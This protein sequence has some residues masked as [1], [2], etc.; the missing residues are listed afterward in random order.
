MTPEIYESIKTEWGKMSNRE[1][2]FLMYTYVKDNGTG[3]PGG[4]IPFLQQHFG[5]QPD[6][7]NQYDHT[8]E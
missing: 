2:R 1:Q 3:V 8:P 5:L 6:T 4:W 7:F